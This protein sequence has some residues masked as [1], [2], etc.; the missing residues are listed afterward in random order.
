[1]PS[2]TNI[3]INIMNWTGRVS[4]L[5]L[6]ACWVSVGYAQR[7]K[8][9]HQEVLD[10][11]ADI[12]INGK[13]DDWGDTLWYE[14]AS[15][16][17]QYH[18]K[19]NDQN[20]FVAFRVRDREQQIQA[21]SQGFSVTVN[22]QGR[23]RDGPTVVYPIADRIAFRSIMS[24]DNDDRPDD[25]REGALQAI[26]SIY[27]LR[28]DDIL[29]GQLSLDNNYGIQAQT[30]IDS[31]DALCVEIVIPLS[32]LGLSSQNDQKLAFN[33]KINGLIMPGNRVEDYRMRSRYPG[34]GYYPA[35]P[36]GRSKP[37]AEPGVWIVS[38]LAKE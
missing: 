15:Q 1:M 35:A 18:L 14:N 38:P 30:L 33:V 16:G 9:H 17:L 11:G 25:M 26:R 8:G 6:L 20:L 2:K 4:L 21:L 37:R 28:F 24:A 19:N 29:D 7:G 12:V 34:Y 23:K 10:W 32:R 27:V 22:P 31:T 3:I 13:L 36:Q 5:L